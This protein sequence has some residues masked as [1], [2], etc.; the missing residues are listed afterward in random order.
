MIETMKNQDKKEKN[1]LSICYLQNKKTWARKTLS[2]T[3][4]KVTS[5]T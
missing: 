1:A 3:N 5:L 2:A 4:S